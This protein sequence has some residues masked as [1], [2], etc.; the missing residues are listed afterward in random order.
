MGVHKNIGIEQDFF[1]KQ[2]DS[3]GKETKV[4]FRFDTSLSIKGTIVRDDAEEPF[5]TIIKLLDGRFVLAT[6]CM[7]SF[8]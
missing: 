4:C 8:V 2:S 1:P 7:Y 3:V 5:Q 6:E